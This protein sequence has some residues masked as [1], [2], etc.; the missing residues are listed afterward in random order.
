M[1]VGGLVAELVGEVIGD[2]L[3]KVII[4]GIGKLI[5]SVYYGLRKLITGK[6]RDIPEVKRIE[7]YYRHK[8]IRLK[9]DFNERI[10]KGTRGTVMEVIDEQHVHVEF[11]DL[12]GKPIVEGDQQVFKIERKGIILERLK[13]RRKKV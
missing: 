5:R 10:L 4:E 1:P 2:L 11:E 9:S 3:F 7:K 6:E 8:K 13:R 12:H